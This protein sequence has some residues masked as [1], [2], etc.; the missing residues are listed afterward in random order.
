MKQIQ[1]QRNVI[2][3][4]HSSMNYRGLHLEIL[5]KGTIG[6]GRKKKNKKQTQMHIKLARIYLI[7]DVVMPQMMNNPCSRF[8]SAYKFHQ[9]CKTSTFLGPCAAILPPDS[10]MF[11]G[12]GLC[13]SFMRLIL[14][15]TCSCLNHSKY[16]CFVTLSS[17][18]PQK[19]QLTIHVKSCATSQSYAIIFWLKQVAPAH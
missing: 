4:Q 5:R 14:T 1:F 6:L 7:L 10:Q 9:T 13:E 15:N 2:I 19:Q 18:C 17:L 16:H 12:L 3:L 8:I 11:W